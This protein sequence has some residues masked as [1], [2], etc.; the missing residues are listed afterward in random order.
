MQGVKQIESISI[1]TQDEQR[2]QVDRSV[3]G[4]PCGMHLQ[5]HTQSQLATSV[6]K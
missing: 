4:H 3:M 1:R 5:H 6:L 2:N